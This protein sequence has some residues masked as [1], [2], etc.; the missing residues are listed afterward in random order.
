MEKQIFQEIK[1][2]HYMTNIRSCPW[3]RTPT[4][5][6]HEILNFYKPFL[7]HHN[8]QIRYVASTG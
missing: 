3:S 8:N 1:H 6:G 4:P 2:V 5:D 7:G